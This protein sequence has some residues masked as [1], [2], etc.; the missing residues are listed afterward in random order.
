[1]LEYPYQRLNH[2]KGEFKMLR[3][4][5]EAKIAAKTAIKVTLETNK[6]SFENAVDVLD[7]KIEDLEDEIDEL[8]DAL[9]ELEG[10]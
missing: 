9:E 6:A 5:I 3:S 7:Q 8:E 2:M 4:Q 1:M 10:E